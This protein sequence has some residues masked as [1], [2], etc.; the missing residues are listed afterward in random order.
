MKLFVLKRTYDV[1]TVCACKQFH[2]N[3]VVKVIAL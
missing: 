1:S 2:I 3:D